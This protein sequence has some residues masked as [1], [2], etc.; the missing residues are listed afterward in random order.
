MNNEY[1]KMNHEKRGMAMILIH[2]GS[3]DCS[4][5][6]R[7]RINVDRDRLKEA[8]Q[9]LSFEVEAPDKLNCEDDIMNIVGEG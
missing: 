4:L 2:K 9:F 3:D 8:L 7:D 6:R 5:E 1:Y